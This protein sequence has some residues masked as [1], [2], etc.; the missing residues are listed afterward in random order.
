MG[1]RW[2]STPYKLLGYKAGNAILTGGNGGSKFDHKHGKA[3]PKSHAAECVVGTRLMPAVSPPSFWRVRL[4][5]L[6]S[7]RYTPV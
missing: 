1:K 3:G 6:P 4:D 7:V 2:G 5:S